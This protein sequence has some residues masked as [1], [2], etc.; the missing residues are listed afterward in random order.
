VKK[1]YSFLHYN[2]YI[3][4][5]LYKILSERRGQASSAPLA[6]GRSRVLIPGPSD[7]VWVFSG[8]FP[9]H[10]IVVSQIRQMLGQYSLL[11]TNHLPSAPILTVPNLPLSVAEKALE[12]LSNP[13]SLG[14]MKDV[15]FP[16]QSYIC[17]GSVTK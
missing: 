16:L 2:E 10:R 1:G 9:H 13:P 3:I 15:S 4:P 7:L 11:R 12:G 14:G 6:L 5:M 17:D 8:V